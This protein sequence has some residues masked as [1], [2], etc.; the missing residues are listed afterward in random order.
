MGQGGSVQ[1]GMLEILIIAEPSVVSRALIYGFNIGRYTLRT[2]ASC[3]SKSYSRPR[4]GKR[5]NQNIML[6]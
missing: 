3:G 5:I 6:L 4:T 2:T 1:C